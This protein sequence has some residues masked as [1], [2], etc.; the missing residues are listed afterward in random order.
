MVMVVMIVLMMMEVLIVKL[1]CYGVACVWSVERGCVDGRVGGAV[2]ARGCVDG[3][4]GGAVMAGSV[5][6]SQELFSSTTQHL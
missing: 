2:M 1:S 6:T 4:V 5:H 3:H